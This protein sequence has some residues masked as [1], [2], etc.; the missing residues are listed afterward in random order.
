MNSFEQSNI[1]SVYLATEG[2]GIHIGRPQ[3]FV[4]YQGCAVGC[5]NCDSKETWDFN[6]RNGLVD[7]V[8]L[9]KRIIKEDRCNS[10]R[11][12]ITGGDPLHSKNDRSVYH[13]ATL[14]KAQ[15]F[16]INI[17]ASG[18]KVVEDI[19]S[20]IDFISFDLKTPSTGVKIPLST[21]NKFL[22][23]FSTK[24]QVKAVI[25]DRAD[26]DYLLDS[27]E[28]LDNSEVPFVITPCYEPHESF[29][30]TLVQKIYE[31]NYNAG[32]PFRVIAQQHKWVFGTKSL[33]V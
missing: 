32:S 30:S 23:S 26:F 8:E 25:A 1:H 6:L 20:L 17:E 3:V 33:N 9:V 14:L 27:Y 19:F 31:W 10:K 13:L 21:L 5:L 12:S 22:T 29:D 16:Y 4:R 11:V 24:A 7:N 28:S 15:G 2:E 18:Q